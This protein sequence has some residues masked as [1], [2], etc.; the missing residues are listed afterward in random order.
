[1]HGVDSVQYGI[2]PRARYPYR[3]SLVGLSQFS[4]IICPHQSYN[5]F[6]RDILFLVI[7]IVTT[8]RK[9]TVLR[10][11]S[12][13]RLEQPFA[14]GEWPV[15]A[16]DRLSQMRN[17]ADLL[18]LTL[19]SYQLFGW[20]L[21]VTIGKN[22][23]VNPADS[24]NYYIP[25]PSSSNSLLKK[26]TSVNVSMPLL[27]Q[28]T[29]L[30]ENCLIVCVIGWLDSSTSLRRWIHRVPWVFFSQSQYITISVKLTSV[31]PGKLEYKSVVRNPNSSRL[32]ESAETVRRNLNKRAGL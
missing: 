10:H 26:V 2:P 32:I 13:K 14:V 23:V 5:K 25:L 6:L 1:V 20:H 28:M 21:C 3:T 19:I 4:A 16:I 27:L 22:D 17:T 8:E 9:Q 12:G 11:Q 7:V 15:R 24:M 18:T 30:S 29:Q 31:R